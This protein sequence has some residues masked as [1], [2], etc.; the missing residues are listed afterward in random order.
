DGR[1]LPHRPDLGPD[2]PLPAGGHGAAASRVHG[3]LAVARP[4]AEAIHERGGRGSGERTAGLPG[5][6]RPAGCRPAPTCTARLDTP[7][8]LTRNLRDSRGGN[9]GTIRATLLPGAPA[10]PV[11]AR[12]ARRRGLQVLLAPAEYL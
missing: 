1:E 7:P 5:W 11:I 4:P 2:A 8:L 6:P 3:R 9:S 12:S 10:S